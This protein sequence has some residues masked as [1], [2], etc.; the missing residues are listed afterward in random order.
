MRCDTAR[1]TALVLAISLVTA[2]TTIGAAAWAQGHRPAGKGFVADQDLNQPGMARGGP[3]PG[4]KWTGPTFDAA[5]K[6]RSAPKVIEGIGV[7][8]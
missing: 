6:R 1:L 8:Y 2:G 4:V 5:R 7:K 3:G